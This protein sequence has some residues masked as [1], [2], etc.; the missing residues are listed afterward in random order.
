MKAK[1][2]VF[3]ERNWTDWYSVSEA[4]EENYIEAKPGAYVIRGKNQ[5]INRLFGV[6]PLG[7]L[8]I[9]QS[10]NLKR[11]LKQFLNSAKYGKS[12]HMAGWRYHTLKMKSVAPLKLLEVCW[13][14]NSACEELECRLMERYIKAFNELPP[15]NYKYNWSNWEE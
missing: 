2:I 3:P 12:G 6:D 5:K 13:A 8:D 4:N 15:L 7:I 1:E 10:T 11:R 9:G 14:Y